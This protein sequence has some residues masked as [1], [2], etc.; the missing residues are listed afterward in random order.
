ML[1]DIGCVTSTAYIISNDDIAYTRI[2]RQVLLSGTFTC[3]FQQHGEPGKTDQHR[4]TRLSPLSYEPILGDAVRT[5]GYGLTRCKSHTAV[6]GWSF[7][8][9]KLEKIYIYG[10]D[11]TLGLE[12]TLKESMNLKVER[13]RK[14]SGVNFQ[15]TTAQRP[16]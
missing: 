9:N 16:S 14:L 12:E 2:I 5:I 15:I 1:I 10:Q 3:Q 8:R 11:L 13:I 4:F 6:S 7:A